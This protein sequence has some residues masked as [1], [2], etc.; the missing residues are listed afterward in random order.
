MG[1]LGGRERAGSGLPRP[2]C[3]PQPRLLSCRVV[4]CRVASRGVVPR[5]AAGSPFKG[6][7]SASRT[8]TTWREAR[9]MCRVGEARACRAS[10]WRVGVRDGGPGGRGGAPDRR[11][12]TI[13]E[14]KNRGRRLPRAS[15][16]R[17]AGARWG[18]R[19]TGGRGAPSAP[20]EGHLQLRQQN[21][22]RPN[23]RTQGRGR[24]REWGRGARTVLVGESCPRN[25]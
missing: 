2:H 8:R 3:G 17:R 20:A 18:G 25:G 5:C 15:S 7:R 9:A 4:S 23:S 14:K 13:C 16:G 22:A 21:S 1:Q 11:R 10:R 12:L 6:A 24:T 19:R